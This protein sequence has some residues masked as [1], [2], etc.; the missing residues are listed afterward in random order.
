MIYALAPTH[1][2]VLSALWPTVRKVGEREGERE[3]AACLIDLPL[4]G[5]QK[6]TENASL[7]LFS[8]CK[9]N[10]HVYG[11]CIACV[12]CMYCVCTILACVCVCILCTLYNFCHAHLLLQL[13]LIRETLPGVV[14]FV[15]GD[16]Q[17]EGVGKGGGLGWET[18]KQQLLFGFY[19]SECVCV[20]VCTIRGKSSN[21]AS[22]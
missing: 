17:T 12:C 7:E 10:L 16:K 6:T 15:T 3:S 2:T 19:V 11:V 13:L 1:G 21:Y 8:H 4:D 20:C 5:A 18:Q 9:C 14:A 22:A